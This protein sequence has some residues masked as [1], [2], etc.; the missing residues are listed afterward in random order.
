MQIRSIYCPTHSKVFWMGPK[1]GK[2]P[3]PGHLGWAVK[4]YLGQQR[5]PRG[6]KMNAFPDGVDAIELDHGGKLLRL[7]KPDEYTPTPPEPDDDTTATEPITPPAVP[8]GGKVESAIMELM[9]QLQA[10]SVDEAKVTAIV[11]RELDKRAT[12]PITV[13]VERPDAEPVKIDGAHKMLPDVLAALQVDNVL[14]VGPTGSGKTYLAKQVSESLA[15]PFFYIPQCNM[16]YDLLGFNNVD[17]YQTTPFRE[18]F[19]ASKEGGVILCDELDGW[20]ESA[21]LAF[22]GATANGYA[23]FPDSPE[24]VLKHPE[25]YIL[26][27]ANTWGHGADREYVGRN[28]LDAATLNRFIPIELDY[29]RGI[30]QKLAGAQGEWLALCWRV[31][32]RTRELKMRHAVS[33]RDVIRG[34]A[35][36]EA[37]MSFDKA[38][39]YVLR[40]NL[41]QGDWERVSR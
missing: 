27:A 31:R 5:L 37:G 24:P 12:E 25:C 3:T 34:R 36:I 39:L 32:E 19:D 41:S 40:R 1:D 28:Q 11:Q 8:K 10:S 26:A 14:L 7:G 21:A 9:T 2:R 4:K 22:N 35:M 20:N 33:T 13:K 30:E 29:D 6:Y 38:S 16:G 17:G 18:G 23:T 15:K